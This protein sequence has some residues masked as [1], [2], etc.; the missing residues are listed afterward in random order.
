MDQT[1]DPNLCE[2]NKYI[3]HALML[4]KYVHPGLR[5]L[6]Q[7]LAD[8]SLG[9]ICYMLFEMNNLQTQNS[10]GKVG[11]SSRGRGQRWK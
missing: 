11:N 3:K 1:L 6:E 2:D 4:L 7:N 9:V 5:T 8:L 10:R